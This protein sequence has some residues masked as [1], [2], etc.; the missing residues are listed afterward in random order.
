MRLK[1]VTLTYIEVTEFGTVVAGTGS[2][3]ADFIQEKEK[4]M[5]DILI[6]EDEE[7]TAKKVK[8]ALELND[9]KAEIAMEKV[10]ACGIGV[11]RGCVIKLNKNDGVKNASVCADGPVF[12]GSEVIWEE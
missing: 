2:S 3:Q 5:N 12:N 8:E 10:M 7:I 6:I 9:I 11:C 1:N 4:N